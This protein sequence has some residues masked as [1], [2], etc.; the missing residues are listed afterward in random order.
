M[1]NNKAT[2][3]GLG[4][5]AGPGYNKYRVTE[6]DAVYFD[7]LEFVS[8][9]GSASDSGDSEESDIAFKAGLTVA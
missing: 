2:T 8:D 5:S 6:D 4:S 1:N 7:V 3:Y 9:E